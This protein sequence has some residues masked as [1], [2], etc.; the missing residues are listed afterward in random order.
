MSIDEDTLLG[1]EIITR[2]ERNDL[3]YEWMGRGGGLTGRLLASDIERGS[4]RRQPY[5]LRRDLADP[6]RNWFPVKVFI[7]AVTGATLDAE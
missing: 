4:W 3:S 1:D 6:N 5:Q 7:A 2:F